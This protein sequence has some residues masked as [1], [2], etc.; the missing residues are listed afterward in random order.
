MALSSQIL[1]YIMP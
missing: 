1:G